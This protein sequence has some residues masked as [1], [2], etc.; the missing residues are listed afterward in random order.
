M[1]LETTS[2]NL[3]PDYNRYSTYSSKDS[4]TLIILM[5][6]S[7]SIIKGYNINNW[8]ASVA[9]RLAEN[10]AFVHGE[11]IIFSGMSYGYKTKMQNVS[12]DISSPTYDTFL[13]KYDPTPDRD[14]QCLYQ[15]TMSSS[16]L[17]NA[18]TGFE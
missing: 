11:H 8:D 5:E 16:E 2:P 4:D 14:I 9:M 15:S 3:R 1:L 6:E 18:A 10:S 13:F 17:R 12:Y 7:G